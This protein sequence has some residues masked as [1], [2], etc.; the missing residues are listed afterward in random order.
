MFERIKGEETTV[1]M[2][3]ILRGL[4][5]LPLLISAQT[6]H[7]VFTEVVLQPSSGEY[8]RIDN[9]TAQAIDLGDYYL[10][11]AADPT[12]GK[13]YYKIAEGTDYWSGSSTDFLVRFPDQS[14]AAGASLIVS[15]GTAANYEATY[16]TAPDLSIKED[17][18]EA[19]AGDN[20][21]GAAPLYLD[22]VAEMLILFKWDGS[23]ATV[24]DVDY[25]LWGDNSFAVDKSS[26]AGYS[27][28][29]PSASQS[30]AAVHL[31]GEKLIRSGNNEGSET[32]SGGNGI[33][34]H[35]E[36]SE[37]FAN[38]WIVADLTVDVPEI[39]GVSFNPDDPSPADDIIVSATVTDAIGLSSV[40]LHYFITDTTILAMSSTG[41]DEYS[42]VIPATGSETTI[43]FFIVAE[44]SS[45]ITK[46]SSTVGITVVEPP[47]P[48]TIA[49]VRQNVDDYIGQEVSFN[50]IVSM[51]SGI[52]RNDRTSMYIQDHSG[53]GINMNQSALLSPPLLRGDSI[54]VTGTVD[55]Y[56]GSL[57]DVT[58]Q[59]SNF[60][61]TFLASNRPVPNVQNIEVFQLNTLQYE[62]SLV[63]I[64]GIV[65][66]RSD[67]IGGGSNIVVEDAT[68]ATTV[69]V[70]DTTNMLS[71]ARAD[72]LMQPGNNIEITGI[73]GSYSS[74]AQLMPGYPEDVQ[75][76]LEGEPGSGETQ[77]SVAPYPFVPQLGER[78]RYDY[79]FPAS[80]RIT[81]RI[82]DASGHFV[83]TLFDDY[84]AL[85]LEKTGYWNGRNE[86][87]ALVPPGTY[88]M[89]LETIN[90]ETGE[91]LHD[92]APV[93]VGTRLK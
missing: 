20:T 30:F 64:S 93:V 23:S 27:A 54:S 50:A 72:S 8:L 53:Y 22:N 91:V 13:Y 82:F 74:E 88:I 86:I 32:S 59:L 46:T 15:M 33:T 26:V 29:T 45:G 87:N 35:D 92:M 71:D 63:T 37:D 55:V 16:G 73:G 10:S 60:T 28:D 24:Q 75:E 77:L 90:R 3:K 49:T 6:D 39:S 47:E 38:T 84:R 1:R 25:L 65:T 78:I 40:S 62:G 52:L 67:G 43:G 21:V 81:L 9:P 70:W 79:S 7:L 89:H 44:N 80:S 18:R 5:L 57:G 4:L 58:V 14:I 76:Q 11:D 31:D 17:F 51:G 66:S 19:V 36:T 42:A 41:G 68:G 69:R 48:L 85:A 83:T 34:G 56:E 61:Y 12:N 2:K